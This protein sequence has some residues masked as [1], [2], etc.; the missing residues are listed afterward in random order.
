LELNFYCTVVIAAD[1]TSHLWGSP[2]EKEWACVRV[3]GLHVGPRV[4]KVILL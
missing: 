2:P 4:A 3:Q 1:W